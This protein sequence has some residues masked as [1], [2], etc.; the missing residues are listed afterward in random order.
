MAVCLTHRHRGR[1]NL[2]ALLQLRAWAEANA[3]ATTV[4]IRRYQPHRE[5]S[6]GRTSAQTGFPLCRNKG[7]RP[8]GRNQMPAAQQ[9]PSIQPL[10]ESQNNQK[11]NAMLP[12]QRMILSMTKSVGV[13]EQRE[14]TMAA[15]L[16]HRY[17]G[18]RNLRALLQLRAYDEIR[19]SSRATRGNDGGLPDPPP[20]RPSQPPSAPITCVGRRKCMSPSRHPQEASQFTGRFC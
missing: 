2:R 19:R 10:Q 4:F 6:V 11:N 15:C 9:M 18:R 16:T 13:H 3:R 5:S 12:R 7:G 1:R 8:S 17:R 20:S 14:A